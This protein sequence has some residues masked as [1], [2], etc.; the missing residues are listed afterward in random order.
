MLLT[1]GISMAFLALIVVT[2][3]WRVAFRV[4]ALN[5]RT[6]SV[7][8]LGLV[9]DESNRARVEGIFDAFAGGFNA[10]IGGVGG[11]AWKSY[12][13]SLPTFNQPF[14]HEGAAM[15]HSLRQLF[16]YDPAEFESTL[17][18]RLP[19]FRYLYYVGLGFWW[20]MRNVEPSVVMKRVQG[21]D[22]L[23]RYLCFDGYGF[24]VAF[25][26]HPKDG[27]AFR[28]LEGFGGYARNAAYHGVGRALWFRYM[29][30]RPALVEQ[31]R[32]LGTHA[33]DAAAGVGLAL[34]FVNPDRLD[35]ARG[36]AQQMPKEWH[37]D[38]HLGMCFGLKARSINHPGQFSKD[39]E[40]VAPRVREAI[41]ASIQACD[42][43]ERSVRQELLSNGYQLWRER[44]THWLTENVE[45]AMGGLAAA[46]DE[47]PEVSKDRSMVL[48]GA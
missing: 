25:F 3:V 45:Y 37:A 39:V 29:D 27:L 11:N 18:N 12:C 1:I 21:L 16:R 24:K 22:P 41:R 26:D 5:A 42:R 48:A 33:T 23:H 43:I 35:L 2:G 30:D 4:F 32:A 44:V 15:G 17:V 46:F 20:G 36:Y 9:V 34:V 47:K 13:D 38:V 7:R 10:M 19:Q 6:M 14:G 8:R 31:L 28:R 40:A